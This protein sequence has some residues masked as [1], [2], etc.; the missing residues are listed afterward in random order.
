MKQKVFSWRDRFF[1]KDE[2]ERDRYSVEGEIFSWG[3]KLHVYDTGGN[4]VAFIRQKIM[5]FMPRFYVEI[6]GRVVC[7]VVQEFTLLRP[8]Y[9]LEGLPWRMEGD[10]W[11]HDY[12]LYNQNFTVMRLYKHWFTWGDSYALEISDPKDEL[13]C[14]CVAL[15]V[16]CALAAT[17]G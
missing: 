1:I 9:R 8:K 17:K 3:K 2:S 5:T 11:G 10:Y 7:E 14:L 16:D 12:S 4:E 13:L 15:A 6:G